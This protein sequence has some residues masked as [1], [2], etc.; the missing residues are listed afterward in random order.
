MRENQEKVLCV[1]EHLYEWDC[2]FLHGEHNYSHDFNI[3]LRASV[4][5]CDPV[6]ISNHKNISSG[7]LIDTSSLAQI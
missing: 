7:C 1:Q 2:C 6:V 3:H 4:A 5:P